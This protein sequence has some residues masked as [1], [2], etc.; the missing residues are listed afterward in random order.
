MGEGASSSGT[1]KEGASPGGAAA[2]MQRASP[3]QAKVFKKTLGRE[4]INLE[5]SADVRFDAHYGLKSDIARGPKSATE[6][7]R[8]AGARCTRSGAS[9]TDGVMR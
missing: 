5:A 6:R 1:S 8:F 3:S 4:P 7:T 9:G 2:E